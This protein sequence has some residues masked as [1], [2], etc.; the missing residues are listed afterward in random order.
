M[1]RTI[2]TTDADA[3]NESSAINNQDTWSERSNS[4]KW[5]RPEWD[6]ASLTF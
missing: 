4:R 6:R 5:R 3:I 1:K 2:A